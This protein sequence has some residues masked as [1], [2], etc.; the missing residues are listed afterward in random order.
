MTSMVPRE[1]VVTAVTSGPLKRI[2][3]GVNLNEQIPLL[4]G[5]QI[6]QLAFVARN[7]RAAARNHA[8][9]FGS[10]PFLAVP[11]YDLGEYRYRGVDGTLDVTSVYGQWGDLQVEFIEVHGSEP[12]AYTD[13][14]PD[15]TEGL[16]HVAVF[17]EDRAATVAQFESAGFE[18]ALFA[19]RTPGHG[20]SIIDTSSLLGHMVEVYEEAKVGRFYDYVRQQSVGFDGTDPVRE[21]DFAALG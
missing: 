6:R 5:R 9:V 12:S 1:A 2:E 4:A 13:L 7:A 14:F 10:G 18:E 11:H 19:A 21:F 8:A 15:G 16:H 17:S 20:Y 3:N